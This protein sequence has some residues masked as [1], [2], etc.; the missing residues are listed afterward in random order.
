MPVEPRARTAAAVIGVLLA[1][2]AACAAS[3]HTTRAEAARE[4]VAQVAE[5][6]PRDAFFAE[7]TA[8]CGQVLT[9]RTVYMVEPGPP[10]EGAKLTWRIATCDD[11]AIRIPFAVDD[12]H[13]RTVVLTRTPEGLLLEHD[14]RHPDGT[15]EEE[16]LYGGWATDDGTRH[17]QRFPAHDA[18]VTMIPAAATNV[19]TL[20]L[21]PTEGELV[22]DLRRHDAPRFRAIFELPGDADDSSP[23]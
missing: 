11:G 18:T 10:F 13:S 8:L 12:D 9:G 1:T 3:H 17:R 16:T 22:Y 23:R 5:D 20:E 6:D 21:R 4:S 7:L 15:P 2:T 14:H 19:W